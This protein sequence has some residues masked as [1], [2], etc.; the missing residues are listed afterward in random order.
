[1]TVDY[2]DEFPRG[3]GD[4]LLKYFIFSVCYGNTGSYQT[5]LS[6]IFRLVYLELFSCLEIPLSKLV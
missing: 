5:E 2:D 6:N 1:M 3:K 4:R